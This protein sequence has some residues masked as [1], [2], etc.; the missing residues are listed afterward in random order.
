MRL[1]IT[2]RQLWFMMSRN[3]TSL[4][5]G[6]LFC[7]V[8]GWSASISFRSSSLW[9]IRKVSM[10]CL[11]RNSLRSYPR[12]SSVWKLPSRQ[13]RVAREIWMRLLMRVSHKSHFSVLKHDNRSVKI[14]SNVKH[15]PVNHKS[16][17]LFAHPGIPPASSM[18]AMPTSQ[19]H[20]SNCHFC[21]PRTP[22]RTEPVWI[23]IRISMSKFCCFLTDLKIYK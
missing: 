2:S 17:V 15:S 6:R 9:Q 13:S 18:L 3:G 22:Q 7:R 5:Q 19:D 4:F 12:P 23:P 10:L 21:S 16:E 8:F 1:E 14:T 11:R 20:T